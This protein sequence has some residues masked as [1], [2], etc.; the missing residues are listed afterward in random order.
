MSWARDMKGYHRNYAI[1]SLSLASSWLTLAAKS[2]VFF[3]QRSCLHITPLLAQNSHYPN[4]KPT[5]TP[6]APLQPH[7][8]G[9]GNV[10]QA[11]TSLPKEY[12]IPQHLG[13]KKIAQVLSTNSSGG[14]PEQRI[15]ENS[16][17]FQSP[18]KRQLP[19]SPCHLWL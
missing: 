18:C 9:Q 19:D 5:F 3:G 15:L 4:P 13:W 12:N 10:F 2:T 8:K 14:L 16:E 6:R 17:S 1:G 11:I 7:Q